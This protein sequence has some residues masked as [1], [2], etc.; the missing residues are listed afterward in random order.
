MGTLEIIL[1]VVVAVVVLL[2]V[3]GYLANAR[4]RGAERSDLLDRAAQADQHLAAA[5]AEDKGWERSGLEA[6]AREAYAAVHGDQP[7][8]LTLVAVVDKPGTEEDEAHFDAD[9]REVVLTR[10]GGSWAAR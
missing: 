1:L 9:G 6:A 8:Q 4:R 7:R 10:R 2:A 5:H 3:G